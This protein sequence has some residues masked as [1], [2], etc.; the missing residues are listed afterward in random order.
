VE[1][2]PLPELPSELLPK[3]DAELP[4]EDD[5][6]L[7]LESPCEL[8][9]PRDDSELPEKD[10]E[11]EEDSEEELSLEKCQLVQ[12]LPE[13]LPEDP[14]LSELPELCPSEELLLPLLL[15]DSPDA[16]LSEAW[17]LS[18]AELSDEPLKLLLLELLG[19]RQRYFSY[20]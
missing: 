16:E 1:E 19:G 10:D 12:E 15:L 14:R 13:E 5:V 3:E 8:L 20:R 11:E 17:E 7:P 4:E 9:L 2:V 6:P 18:L